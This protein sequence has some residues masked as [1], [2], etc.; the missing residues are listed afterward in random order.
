[1]DWSVTTEAYIEIITRKVNVWPFAKCPLEIFY[2]GLLPSDLRTN[3]S[4]TKLRKI[5]FE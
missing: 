4:L 1:M 3:I 5:Q 2:M